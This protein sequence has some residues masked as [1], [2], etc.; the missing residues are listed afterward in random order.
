M[1]DRLCSLSASL[2]ANFA[3]VSCFG[4]QRLLPSQVRPGRYGSMLEIVVFSR[5]LVLMTT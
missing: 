2:K 4:P 1:T 3:F 5:R